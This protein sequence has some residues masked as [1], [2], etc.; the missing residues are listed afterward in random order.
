MQQIYAIGR[1][2][3]AHRSRVGFWLVAGLPAFFVLLVEVHLFPD[4]LENAAVLGPFFLLIGPLWL[5]IF[6]DPPFSGGGARRIC[7]A[8]FVLIASVALIGIVASVALCLGLLFPGINLG[9]AK[10]LLVSAVPPRY[11]FYSPGAMIVLGPSEHANFSPSFWLWILLGCGAGWIAFVG[12]SILRWARLPAHQARA[13][14]LSKI[15][16]LAGSALCLQCSVLLLLDESGL[17]SEAGLRDPIEVLRGCGVVTLGF[18]LA[19]AYG[20]ADLAAWGLLALA[21]H[22]IGVGFLLVD[23]HSRYATDDFLPWFAAWAAVLTAPAFYRLLNRNRGA[24]AEIG[25]TDTVRRWEAGGLIDSAKKITNLALVIAVIG[26]WASWQYATDLSN[27]DELRT[28]FA[29]DLANLRIQNLTKNPGFPQP[30][31]N[32]ALAPPAAGGRAAPTTEAAKSKLEQERNEWIAR[33]LFQPDSRADPPPW[34]FALDVTA[35]GNW[36][37]ETPSDFSTLVVT[38]TAF[39]YGIPNYWSREWAHS[40]RLDP[41][42]PSETAATINRLGLALSGPSREAGNSGLPDFYP[43]YRSAEEQILNRKVEVPGLNLEIPAQFTAMGS[44]LFVCCAMWFFAE[45][46]NSLAAV[47]GRKE[48]EIPWVFVDAQRFRTKAVGYLWRVALLLAPWLLFH[49]IFEVY[50]LTNRARGLPASAG[51]DR[52]MAAALCLLLWI[53]WKTSSATLRAF[54]QLSLYYDASAD[55]SGKG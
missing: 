46:V 48:G 52:L 45:R 29:R 9:A 15:A 26:F 19:T 32:A 28:A 51:S 27:L 23:P 33:R 37:G 7:H 6:C 2:L 22:G 50:L 55:R 16:G 12:L 30:V 24:E 10:G 34:A 21:L 35:A 25:P 54:W 4:W 44:W 8:L 1:W 53:G 3:N 47:S 18:L 39:E 13:A 20:M 42:Q 40:G 5:A 49:E 14:I 36:A 38:V 11:S 31:R 41:G 43:I 17:S